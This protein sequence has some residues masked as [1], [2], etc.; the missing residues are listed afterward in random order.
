M[1]L[2]YTVCIP[3][4]MW[5]YKLVSNSSHDTNVPTA[6][7]DHPP[8]CESSSCPPNRP[9]HL[10][11]PLQTQ[12]GPSSGWR[13]CPVTSGSQPVVPSPW[14]LWWWTQAS[15][16]GW[17]QSAGPRAGVSGPSSQRPQP[18]IAASPCGHLWETWWPPSCLRILPGVSL[19]WGFCNKWTAMMHEY[20]ND[21]LMQ[22]Y[23]PIYLH[24]L[25]FHCHGN[26]KH[27]SGYYSQG[28]YASCFQW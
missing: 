24:M 22:T 18:G 10:Q 12:A 14:T 6:F 1:F 3:Y 13:P 4:C 26:R 27:F 16:P 11:R 21:I 9:S 19:I 17:P 15:R 8:T 28:V 2:L 23:H 5:T 25:A 7:I 20:N